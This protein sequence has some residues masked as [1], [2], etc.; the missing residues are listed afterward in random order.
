ML[1]DP[2]VWGR[3]GKGGWD[4]GLGRGDSGGMQEELMG[5]AVFQG[6]QYEMF[7]WG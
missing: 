2:H 3:Q 5:N 6:R 1:L 4:G 7:N